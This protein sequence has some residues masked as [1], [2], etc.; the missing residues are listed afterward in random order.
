[1]T[2][3]YNQELLYFTLEGL[4]IICINCLGT[5]RSDHLTAFGCPLFAAGNYF[6]NLLSGQTSFLPGNTAEVKWIHRPM[7]NAVPCALQGVIKITPPSWAKSITVFM[8]LKSPTGHLFNIG[9][10]PTND[11]YGTYFLF[12]VH[13]ITTRDCGHYHD[14]TVI[15]Y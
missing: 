3:K 9:D 8:K 15:N 4:H 5:S 2:T 1:M 13:Y 12:A 7:A 10:S 11:G 6:I 14:I